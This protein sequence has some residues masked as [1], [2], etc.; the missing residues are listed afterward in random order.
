MKIGI[1][2][3]GTFLFVDRDRIGYPGGIGDEID[4]TGFTKLVDLRLNGR[5]LGGVDRT[6]LL[7]NGGFNGTR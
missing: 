5:G 2:V 4:E 6:L 3:N 7:A 1:D